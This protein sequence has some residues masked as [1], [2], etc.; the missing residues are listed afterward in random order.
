[1][2]SLDWHITEKS[3]QEKPIPSKSLFYSRF[4]F[5]FTLFDK[6]YSQFFIFNLNFPFLFSVFNHSVPY[7]IQ[8]LCGSHRYKENILTGIV[9][10]QWWL[11]L[12]LEQS[13]KQWWLKMF[14]QLSAPWVHP[15]SFGCAHFTEQNPVLQ[16]KDNIVFCENRKKRAKEIAVL[17]SCASVWVCCWYVVRTQC[18]C[19]FLMNEKENRFFQEKL[20]KLKEK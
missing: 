13:V 20:S 3:S 12:T 4:I 10:G 15:F 18:L 14:V 19:G 1:M 16:Q 2:L 17:L 11:Y 9:Q 8:I 5:K 6:Y 7:W